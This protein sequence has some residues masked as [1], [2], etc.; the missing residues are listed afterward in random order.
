LG[1]VGAYLSPAR[2]QDREADAALDLLFQLGLP[3]SRGAKWVNVRNEYSYRGSRPTFTDAVLSGKAWLI[4]ERPNGTVELITDLAQRGTYRRSRNDSDSNELNIPSAAIEPADLDQDIQALKELLAKE[5]TSQDSATEYDQINSVNWSG[6]DGATHPGGQALL[7]LAHLKRNGRETQARELF[8]LLNK[9]VP[10]GKDALDAAVSAIGDGRLAALNREWIAKGDRTAYA[11]AL[12]R[13]TNELNRGWTNRDAVVHLTRRVRESKPAPQATAPD[14][15]AAA[16]LLFSLKQADFYKLPQG[17]N[18]LIPGGGRALPGF[19]FMYQNSEDEEIEITESATSEVAPND[20]LALFFSRKREAA[21]ALTKLIDDG[22]FLRITQDE[23]SRSYRFFSSNDSE[24]NRLAQAYASLP[25]PM[26][27]G[28]LAWRLIESLIPNSERISIEDEDRSAVVKAWLARIE[29]KTDEELAWDSMRNASG[30]YDGDF[31]NA[32]RF[33]VKNG[34]DETVTK[35]RDVFVD[36]AVWSAGSIDPVLPPLEAYLKR[37]KEDAAPFMEKVKSACAI[38]LKERNEQRQSADDDQAKALAGELKKLD[39]LLKPSTLSDM[40]GE[41]EGMDDTEATVA[42]QS[43]ASAMRKVPIN[44]AEPQ[45]LQA[46]ARNSN[47]STTQ[48]LLNILSQ[49]RFMGFRKNSESK[50]A[51]AATAYD[52][53]TCAAVLKLL[54]DQTEDSADDDESGSAENTSMMMANLVVWPRLTSN[55]QEKWTTLT[56]RAPHLYPRWILERA[57]AIAEGKET[58]PMPDPSHVSAGKVQELISSLA[59]LSPAKLMEQFQALSSDEQ[60]ALIDHLA[61]TPEW[62]P[63]FRAAQLSIVKISGDAVD[64]LGAEAW[65]GRSLDE[66]FE[67]EIT[68]ATEKVA[69]ENS[70]VLAITSSGPLSGLSVTAK[71]NARQS[72]SPDLLKEMGIPGLG[73]RRVPDAMMY[74]MLKLGSGRESGKFDVYGYPM[75]KDSTVLKAWREENVKPVGE[76]KPPGRS[77]QM[78]LDPRLF[79]KSF[80]ET[81]E[82]KSF[83][84]PFVLTWNAVMLK[85]EE[86]ENSETN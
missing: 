1:G 53:T 7:F 31:L 83:A 79:Q 55:E 67:G 60:L 81:L 70:I 65:K 51:P 68:A 15:E 56:Q 35:L 86:G 59:S 20:P 54:N 58:P 37:L 36:P 66:S 69:I 45:I 34:S 3:D 16:R 24:E 61:K 18:W 71:S 63:A 6:S 49:S 26:E 32:L 46:A 28:E 29:N 23:A 14:A 11:N 62:P 13:L 9:R 57:R 17:Q 85:S 10:I 8:G 19:P 39:R 43:I 47:A 2:A 40:L 22:R 21:A 72:I 74:R 52:E 73:N 48:G 12:E 80:K 77:R 50:A 75:W 64:K 78:P 25:R 42:L 76:P 27:L 38:A 44:E 41:L 82:A 84:V 30:A 4:S 33:L 5:P